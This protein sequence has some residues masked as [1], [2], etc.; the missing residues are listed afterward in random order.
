MKRR[1]QLNFLTNSINV[2]CLKV[3]KS[4]SFVSGL[5]FEPFSVLNQLMTL[6]VKVFVNSQSI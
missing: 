4:V 2:G 5:K 3:D 1:V 6:Y